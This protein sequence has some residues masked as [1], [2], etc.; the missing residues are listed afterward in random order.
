MEKL[1]ANSGILIIGGS[2]TTAT[3][4]SGVTYYLLTNPEAMRKLTAEIRSSFRS[5]DEI[6]FVSVSAL[7]YLLAC[8][9]E[10][11]R[12]Y[13]PVPNGLPRTVPKGGAT[14]AGHFVPED[15][16]PWSSCSSFLPFLLPLLLWRRW[17]TQHDTGAEHRRRP[18]V[19]HVPQREELHGPLRVPPGAVARGPALRGRQPGRIPA[20]PSRAAEL[21][22]QEVSPARIS[23]PLSSAPLF[24]TPLAP[25]EIQNTHLAFIKEKKSLMKPKIKM[26]CTSPAD[27]GRF[28]NRSKKNSL[29]YIEMRI[30]LA[31]VLWNF[32]M[33][34]ADD[35]RDW[36][37]KQRIFNFWEK[38]PLNAFLTPVAR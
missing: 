37:A 14:V 17:L 21:P 6:D 20:F 34:I 18:P 7:P 32:D 19:G 16:S 5:E 38:G 25:L 9:D 13:P 31:R 2:E 11:L 10:A 8:L 4:L 15:V 1:Q 24:L 12:M 26:K 3:L 23:F 29:A 30:I 36:V 33:R 22:R 35:S 28:G 27:H